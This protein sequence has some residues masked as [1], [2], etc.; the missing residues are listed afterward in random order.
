MKKIILFFIVFSASAF[1]QF[2]P[3]V[4][5]VGTSAMHKDSSAFT[6][7]FG[8]STGDV[9]NINR[10]YQ[11]ISNTSLGY[12]NVG[13]STLALEK[14]GVNSVV[15]LGDGGE[16]IC[17]L[18]NAAVSLIFNG[19]GYDFAVFENSF[20][21]SFL[22]LAFVEVSSDG[23]NYFRFPATSNTDTTVQ[24]GSFGSTDPTLINNLAG[25]YRALYGTP[26]DLEELKNE[27]GLDVDHI[28]YIKIIDVVGSVQ[29][30]YASRDQYGHKINDPWPTAFGSSGF[31]LDAVGIINAVGDGVEELS[32]NYLKIYPN[33]AANN[34]VITL[35]NAQGNI[36]IVDVEGKELFS[37]FNK[38]NSYSISLSFLNS[39][40]YFVTVSNDHSVKTQKLV[41]R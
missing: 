25:K 19:P 14:A 15:S 39:G 24:T 38:E 34:D 16:A 1:A 27:A 33:P 20:S 21:D 13:D 22:E 35:L 4:G 10:G 41:V 31:D 29:N 12:A 40:L 9:V 17:H 7:W 2:A 28:T 30:A 5:Q 36:S 18:Q 23:V 8:E 37:A 11:D 6:Y 32:K 26:F 3:A